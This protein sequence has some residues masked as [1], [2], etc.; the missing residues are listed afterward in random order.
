MD[1]PLRSVENDQ[2][3]MTDIAKS[4]ESKSSNPS[5]PSSPDRRAFLG[6]VGG[7]AATVAA[8]LV[9]PEVPGSTRSEAAAQEI[10]PQAAI[11]PVT[12]RKREKRAFNLRVD[13]A[14]RERDRPIADHPTNGD[15]DLFPGKIGNYSK[16]LPH[17][18]LG[19][20]NIAAYN[21]LIRA[22]TTGSPADFE[23]ITTGGPTKQTNPQ[24]GLA[25]DM[26]GSDS[27]C[28]TMRA[29]PAFSSAE[30]AGEIA[31]NYWMAL[32]RDV[33]FNEY[34]THPL[35]NKAAADLSQFSD[36]RGPKSGGSVTTGTLF[37]ENFPGA[38]TGPYIS[39]FMW[40]DTPF[41]AESVN[42]Q[43]RTRSAGIDYLTNYQDWLAVQNG[44]LVAD[45]GF[46]STLR[47]IRSGRDLAEWV[48]IDVL[49][50]AYFNALLIMASTGVPLDSGN[51]YKSSSNQIGF[52]TLGAPYIASLVCAVAKP[53]LKTVWYQKWFVHRRL[54]PEEFAGRV[55]N[56]L[57]GATSYPIH[58]DIL[59]SAV[60]DE[61]FDRFGAYLLPM[62]FPEG[63][64]TH[65]A[66]GAGHATVAG[67]CVTV[68]KAFFDESF[69]IQNPVEASSDGTELLPYTGS[70]LTVGGELNKL[71]INVAFGRNIAGVHWRTDG[72]ES[73]K[74]GEEVAIRFLRDERDCFNEDFTGYSLTKFD[75]TTVTV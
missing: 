74:L 4:G 31:E 32:L 48:H 22:L 15:E 23:N 70:A 26:E 36:F 13:A 41:G 54:R 52:G 20:V 14:R 21:S 16:G 6:K 8:G 39:Q 49:F 28:F 53:A 55:H 46:D 60:V 18:D 2:S 33:P 38:L 62:A 19:E 63:C 42:R 56:H 51:P 17:N 25:F 44:A 40:L 11:G 29:A 27:H 35:A 1:E 50:Q 58:A 37:R 67:A 12:G 45:G 75:G 59:N 73:L 24:S 43:M 10:G 34:A 64:P 61:V 5:H 69:V 30:E 68:L 47:Y 7:V 3:K 9:L 57:T 65:P 66:Y 72:T 71:A